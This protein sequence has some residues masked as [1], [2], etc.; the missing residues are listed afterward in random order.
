MPLVFDAP[1]PE[2]PISTAQPDT[3]AAASRVLLLIRNLLEVAMNRAA[4]AGA[5]ANAAQC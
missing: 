5:G 2:Q 1:D 4:P 3:I